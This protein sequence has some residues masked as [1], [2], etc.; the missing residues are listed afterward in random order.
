MTAKA[1]VVYDFEAAAEGELTVRA[2]DVVTLT[3]D[4]IGQG[5]V[6]AIDIYGRQGIIPEDY[7]DKGFNNGVTALKPSAPL[8]KDDTWDEEWD[9]DEDSMAPSKFEGGG[10]DNVYDYLTTGHHKSTNY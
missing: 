6:Y 5:W 2:G 9:S 1:R 7:L 4:N 8:M 3:D 10:N